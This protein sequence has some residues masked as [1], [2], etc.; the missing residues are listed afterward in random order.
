MRGRANK[1]GRCRQKG[2]DKKINKKK[3][4][5]GPCFHRAL[6]GLLV[7]LVQTSRNLLNFVRKHIR[8]HSVLFGT[9]QVEK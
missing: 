5:S 4:K 6:F 9:F 1:F 2:M 3:E 7:N 8:F